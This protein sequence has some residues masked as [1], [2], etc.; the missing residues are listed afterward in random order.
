MNQIYLQGFVESDPEVQYFAYDHAR[1]SFR[2]RTE[3]PMPTSDDPLR[4]IKQWHR[5]A[6]WGTVA[7][8]IEEQVRAGDEI[9]LR[10]RISYYR[11]TNRA[12]E[13]YQVTEIECQGLETLS[14][15]RPAIDRSAPPAPELDWQDFAPT[16]DEDPMA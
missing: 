9:R 11:Q 14:R 7:T 6:A 12:G 4:T 8:Q 13:T 16:S 2:L 1:A 15:P 3:E 10:G 5:I